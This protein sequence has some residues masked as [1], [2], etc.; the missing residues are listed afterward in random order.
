MWAEYGTA[1]VLR[2][3]I[4]KILQ[5][6]DLLS[7]PYQPQW[8][9]SHK[10]LDWEQGPHTAVRMSSLPLLFWME[11]KSC[12]AGPTCALWAPYCLMPHP[13][14][15]TLPFLPCSED[16]GSLATT[17]I[18]EH[19]DVPISSW[20]NSKGQPITQSRLHKSQHF[21]DKW[22]LAHLPSSWLSAKAVV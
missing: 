8:Q 15:A 11:L 13:A 21:G 1:D 5:G 18:T 12:K 7:P 9:A 2:H 3:E 20:A 6:P 10:H 17:H 22:G 4:Y 19:P 14:A 16:F